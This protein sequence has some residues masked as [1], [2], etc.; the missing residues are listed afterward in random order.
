[1]RASRT[2]VS[3]AELEALLREDD[4]DLRGLVFEGVSLVACDL[5]GADLRAVTFRQCDLSQAALAG[6]LLSGARFEGCKAIDAALEEADLDE[7]R[8]S[9]VDLTGA[10][11]HRDGDDDGSRNGGGAEAPGCGA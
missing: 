3:R 6:A 5:S 8:F 4:A 1:M 11:A 7:A 2:I 9:A 10:S